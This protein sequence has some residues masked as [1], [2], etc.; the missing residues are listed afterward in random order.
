MSKGT[1]SRTESASSL[2]AV[3]LM[4]FSAAL[5]LLLIGT[6]ILAGLHS[7]NIVKYLKEHTA[8]V[9]E[10]NSSDPSVIKTLTEDL[11][12]DERLRSNTI[13]HIT[14]EE[15]LDFMQDE[16][17]TDLLPE[18]M[19][20]PFS[21]IVSSYVKEAY[22]SEEELH[23]IRED[24][25][26]KFNISQVYF[27]NDYLAFW[28]EWK[29]KILR[30]TAI[31]ALFLLLITIMLIFNTVKLSI[32]TRKHSIEILELVGASWNFIRE[33]FLRVA[34]KM[35][36]IS[37][38]LASILIALFLSVFLYNTPGLIDYFNWYYLLVTIVIL[39][40]LGVVLQWLST[41]I[42]INQSL[43]HAVSSYK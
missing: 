14:S 31:S 19:D 15:G 2:T 8:I 7:E 10:L 36:I 11:K 27:Q 4:I 12:E 18:G 5:L 40:V 21:D 34:I 25:M 29:G 20:N 3:F 43:K 30:I 6:Y 22:T 35:G 17:G 42:V 38:L 1:K 37:A 28:D 9:F 33:P 26:G 16:M 13:E 39:I 23:S 32:Y 41:Y 24:W